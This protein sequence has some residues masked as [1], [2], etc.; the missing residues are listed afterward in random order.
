MTWPKRYGGHERS[1]LERYVVTEELLAAGAPVGS[2]WVADRQSGPLLLRYGTEE[3]KLDYCPRIARGEIFFSIGMSEPDTGSDLASLRTR[4]VKV[5]GGWEITGTKIW[6]SGAHRNHYAIT[7]CRTGP[8]E[9]DRHAGL[10]QFVVDL[11]GPG[12]TIRPIRNLAGRREDR[13]STRLNS[14]HSSISYAVLCL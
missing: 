14:S 5:E 3:Q 1:A 8:A 11:K 4:A 6:T 7:L 9:P 2:H 10:S 12:I 13:K